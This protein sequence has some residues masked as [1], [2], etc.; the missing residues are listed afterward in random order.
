MALRLPPRQAIPRVAALIAAGDDAPACARAL[1][2]AVALVAAEV[3]PL[4]GG[5]GDR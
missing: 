2:A 5:D 4:E 1:D 3:E